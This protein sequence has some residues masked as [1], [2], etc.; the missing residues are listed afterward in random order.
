MRAIV[1]SHLVETGIIMLHV[2]S[3]SLLLDG[4]LH[5]VLEKAVLRP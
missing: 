4:D 5:A 3:L 1:P 2:S